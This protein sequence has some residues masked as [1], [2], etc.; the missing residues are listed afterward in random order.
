[1]IGKSFGK[2]RIVDE[3]GRGALGT[4]YRAID[5]SV[6]REVAIRMLRPELHDSEAL[7]RFMADATTL[8]KLNRHEH[9]AV[10]GVKK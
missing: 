2:Y 7:K 4:V 5:D 6:G 1:M 8:A 10:Y 3:L 9:A